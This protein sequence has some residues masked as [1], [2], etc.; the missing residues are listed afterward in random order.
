MVK[1]TEEE[2][3]YV[4]I[5]LLLSGISQRAAR[6]F[7]DTEFVPSCLYQSFKKE[8]KTLYGLKQ[9]KTINQSQW[10]RLFPLKGS[11][12]SKTFDVT[13]II[14]LLRNLTDLK[15]PK[16]GFDNLPL[17]S[18]TTPSA[19]LATIKYYRNYIAH[20]EDGKIESSFFTKAWQDI[21]G[22]SKCI[23]M[24][25]FSSRRRFGIVVFLSSFK[26]EEI[27]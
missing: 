8:Y 22:V 24:E 6:S 15:P 27:T 20:I 7:F 14:L 23:H 17:A 21:I 11:P 3:N 16:R 10:N 12:D 13:L 4:R 9:E 26:I 1:I 2:D 5:C 18:D 25:L 19:D